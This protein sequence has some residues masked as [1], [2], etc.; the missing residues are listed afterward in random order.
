[1]KAISQRKAFIR[2][3]RDKGEGYKPEKGIYLG[4][5]EIKAKAISHREE[6]IRGGRDQGEG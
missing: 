2:G 6:F 4:E 5:V 1:V 3:G